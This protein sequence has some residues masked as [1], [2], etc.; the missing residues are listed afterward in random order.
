MLPLLC[1]NKKEMK[2][3]L[4]FFS[5]FSITP[6]R[7]W[8][9]IRHKNGEDPASEKTEASKKNTTGKGKCAKFNS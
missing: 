9:R 6:A 8:K 4:I 2:L 5:G 7:R 3:A 1:K